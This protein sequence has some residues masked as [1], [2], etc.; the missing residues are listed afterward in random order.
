MPYFD[1]NDA[2]H[3]GMLP[4]GARTAAG[5]LATI[6]A[7]VE[8]EVVAMFT[9]AGRGSYTTAV[10][11]SPRPY[12]LDPALDLWIFLAGYNPDPALATGGATGALAS[13]LRQVIADV[14]AHRVA[15]W[16]VSPAVASESGTDGRKGVSYRDDRLNPFP[17]G[18]DI[19]LRPY[20]LRPPATY[21]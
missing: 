11:V 6:A 10:G 13:A 17:P 9:K 2:E 7:R 4:P 3:V 8:R 16:R 14:I 12:A 19:A 20:D 18:W 5:D 21:I 1:V 15:N